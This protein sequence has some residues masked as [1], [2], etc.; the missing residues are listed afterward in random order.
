MTKTSKYLFLSL[1][2][3]LI[4]SVF[5]YMNRGTIRIHMLDYLHSFDDAVIEDESDIVPALGW[6]LA[7]DGG[8]L[9]DTTGTS[10]EQL[11]SLRS[12]GYLSGYEEA[13]F[14]SNVTLYNSELA[15]DGY[16]VIASANGFG[17]SMIDM[18][19]NIVHE[20]F[21]H[22]ITL[23]GLWPESRDQNT[24]SEF[25]RR[26]YLF[27]NGDLLVL[28]KD[29]GIFKLDR[30][31][32]LL[33][34]SNYINA[35]H[36]LDVGDNGLI[37]ALGCKININERYNPNDY[38][39]EDYLYIL[40]SL[41]NT[42]DSMSI[43][44]LVSES[45][46]APTLRKSAIRNRGLIEDSSVP[47]SMLIGDVLHTNT[48]AY[49]R[50]GQL[51]EDYEGPLREGSVLLS[52][53]KIDLVCAL[54]LESRL[55]YW[56]ESDLWHRQHEPVLLPDG[57]ILIFDNMGM[58]E[59]ST[60][61]EYDPRTLEVFWLYRGDEENPFYTRGMGSCQRLPNGNTLI[62]ESFFGRA[63]EVTPEKE[64]VWE[65]FS[66]Y[67]AGD[68]N[69]LIATLFDVFRVPEDYVDGWLVVE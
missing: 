21:S 30:E 24:E 15:C 37:Y 57:N 10:Q 14:M 67:R 1:I 6:G 54:D 29:G 69:E 50:E 38:I 5:G 19:G 68:D 65:Y 16:N 56:A 17:V 20:W 53:R 47:E 28:M 39:S 63:F 46:F 55:I 52:M 33:W 32:N 31:S 41:G 3:A 36:D 27:E 45:Q 35:H 25:W 12:L 64:I 44:D 42:I 4:I 9:G 48:V 8:S 58:G 43:L 7:R 51:P 49:I 34:T 66:P 13:P 11:E 26:A 59:V 2:L 18:E 60:V 62:T 23:H 22:D 61:L 40:D